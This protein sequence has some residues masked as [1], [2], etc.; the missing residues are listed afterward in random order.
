MTAEQALDHTWF[1][2]Q[3]HKKEFQELY[4][5]T[6]RG[7]QPRP[8]SKHL[9]HFLAKGARAYAHS[10]GILERR[11]RNSSDPRAGTAVE[12]HC[13]PAPRAMN[14]LL[15]PRGTKRARTCS[16]PKATASVSQIP[17]LGDNQKSLFFGRIQDNPTLQLPAEIPKLLR[18]SAS[19]QTPNTSE[20]RSRETPRSPLRPVYSNAPPVAQDGN[21]KSGAQGKPI[22]RQHS[23]ELRR[24]ST[25]YSGLPRTSL[26][27]RTQSTDNRLSSPDTPMKQR[28]RSIYDLD[29]NEE[30]VPR[31][32][33]ERVQATQ[34]NTRDDLNTPHHLSARSLDDM[35]D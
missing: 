24:K 28:T 27:R 3:C 35:A 31:S 23:V 22:D 30:Q 15:Y 32:S 12:A 9:F 11:P 26:R 5:R 4:Q 25:L 17:G 10:H 33:S 14:G 1:S 6:I 19:F 21:P 29:E 2:N 20:I 8:P 7:W 18:R 34:W 16:A 13:R